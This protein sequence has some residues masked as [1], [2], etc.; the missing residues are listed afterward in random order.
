MEDQ[1]G[2]ETTKKKRKINFPRRST[3]PASQE[4]VHCLVQ[5]QTQLKKRSIP[6]EGGIQGVCL[7]AEDKIPGDNGHVGDNSR[8]RQGVALKLLRATCQFYVWKPFADSRRLAHC[9]HW[10]SVPL[11]TAIPRRLHQPSCLPAGLSCVPSLINVMLR[12]KR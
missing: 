1:G 2:A 5:N 9:E 8:R 10:R 7:E 11:Y 12:E 4:P 3:A 6:K